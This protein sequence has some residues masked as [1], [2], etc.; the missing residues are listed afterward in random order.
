MTAD[1]CLSEP[2]PA[3]L[4]GMLE[5]QARLMPG[6]AAIATAERR[7]T[8]AELAR[9]AN[10]VAS[11]LR[12]FG[13][14]PEARIA[15]AIP[16]SPELIAALFGVLTAGA[17]YVPIDVSY[18]LARAELMLR[19]TGAEVLITTQALTGRF[20]SLPA[21]VVAIE[22]LLEPAT[23]ASPAQPACGSANLAYVIHTSGSTGE[24]KGVLVEHRTATAM[25]Q[26]HAS[27]LRLTGHDRVLQF[28][29]LVADGSVVEI[30]GALS[31]GA[32]LCFATGWR[33]LVGEILEHALRELSVTLT[34]AT[35]SAL[36]T[37]GNADPPSSLRTV[38]VAG[39]QCPRQLA[40][41]WIEKCELINAYGPTE[42]SVSAAGWPVKNL[43]EPRVR[44]GPPHPGVTIHVLDADFHPVPPGEDGELCI[45]G[46][47]VTRGYDGDPRLTALRFMPNPFSERPGA[48]LYRTGDLGRWI[49]GH[50]DVA[51]RLDNQVKIRGF[52][53]EPGEVEA[54]LR[55]HPSVRD[56]AVV[57]RSGTQGDAELVAFVTP[58]RTAEDL[59]RL[60]AFLRERVPQPL[61]P[62]R[63]IALSELPRQLSGKVDH[64]VLVKLADAGAG[65]GGDVPADV[66]EVI[67]RFWREL[68]NVPDVDPRDDFFEAG[69]N[70]L[71]AV[72]L[73]SRIRDSF[74]VDVPLRTF[75]DA[76]TFAD[77]QRE[78]ES[79]L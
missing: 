65:A 5:D 2:V 24:P 17:A 75:F 30:F 77:V 39:E 35:P 28:F 71:R 38:V 61:L 1:A 74:D 50:V 6:K 36:A 13:A 20:A 23:A 16:K 67:A 60:R 21:T 43:Q 33:P 10:R 64:A 59:E 15:L 32:T 73:L 26:A 44:V 37:L 58:E 57:S 25:V 29:P 9:D 27:L 42:A 62:A 48:R 63:V 3:L 70:S 53:V 52:R 54:A 78:V 72:Q 68:L 22:S 47:G 55:V 7:L 12:Q 40:E 76:S 49:G 56:A 19:R 45:G 18:P 4:H 51:G 69:G 8:Y 46:A 41:R 79:A 66:G 31:R 11:H 34:H 14:R